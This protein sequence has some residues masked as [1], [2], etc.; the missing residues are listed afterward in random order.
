MGRR[1]PIPDTGEARAAW[2]AAAPDIH[3]PCTPGSGCAECATTLG[4]WNALWAA[5]WPEW[6]QSDR[7]EAAARDVL[8]AQYSAAAQNQPP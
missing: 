2:Y 6:V 5:E 7:V 4:A 8:T 1:R 3:A